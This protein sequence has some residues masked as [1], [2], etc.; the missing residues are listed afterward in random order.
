MFK[1]FFQQ[2]KKEQAVIE[3]I[4]AHIRLLIAAC[5]GFH[6]GLSQGNKERILEVFHIEREAD[7]VR[8]EIIAAVYEGAFLPYLRPNLCRLVEIVDG[9]FDNIEDAANNYVAMKIPQELHE[10][11]VRVAFYN[12]RICEMLL[13]SF[14]SLIEGGSLREKTLAVRIYEKKIDDIKFETRRL[15]YRIPV[16]DFW[17][18]RILA[19]F[20]ESLTAI[21]DAVE[22]ASDYLHI[23]NVSMK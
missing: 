1:K 19:E 7:T 2:G 18:G 21:S 14:Q 9:V 12:I 13:I 20:F 8:R 10:P 16:Q 6:E 11:S 5:E 3:K 15:L 23:I 17:A 4:T 22:D